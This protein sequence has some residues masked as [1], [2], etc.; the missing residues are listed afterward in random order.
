MAD[1]VTMLTPTNGQCYEHCSPHYPTD[2][3]LLYCSYL[4]GKPYPITV[5]DVEGISLDVSV[6]SNNCQHQSLDPTNTTHIIITFTD[7]ET[8]QPAPSVSDKTKSSQYGQIQVG[9]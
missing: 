6:R 1:I 4:P 5:H 9:P 2:S 8:V 3:V 7:T